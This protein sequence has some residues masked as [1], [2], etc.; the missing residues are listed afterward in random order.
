MW[1][2]YKD[3]D[4]VQTR[5]GMQL[6]TTFNGELYGLFFYKVN[7]TTQ[8]LVHIGTKLLKWNNY[9][10]TPASTTELYTGLNPRESKSFIF[11]NIF[12]FMDG[13]NY[14]EYDGETIKPVEGTIPVTTYFMTPDGDTLLDDGIDSDKIYQEV[15]VLTSLRTNRFYGD[16]TSVDYHL[17]TNNLDSASKY[18]IN[19]IV[20]GITK[21]ENIDFTVDRTTGIVTFNTA[22]IKE[23]EVYITFS[24]TIADQKERILNCTL[25]TDF[26]NSI[27][28]S[29]NPNY[30]NTIFWSERQNPRYIKET[31][32]NEAGLDFS[33]VKAIIP[34]NNVLW[35]LKE[36]NQNFSSLYYYVPT[37][38]ENY[39]DTYSRN[40]GSISLGCVSTGINFNDDIVFFSTKGLEGISSSSMYS[41][42]ILQHRS[43][44]VDSK[45]LVETGYKD[46][47]L[48]EWE[49]Y[50]LCLI[51]SHI[52]LADSRQKFQNN[53]NDIEYEWFY[54]ELP[55][56]ITYIKEY[57]GDLYLGNNS[58]QLFKLDGTSDNTRD[59]DSYWTTF[60]D[61]Y[62]YPGY[63]KTTNKR[64]NVVYFK[65]MNN[66]EVKLSTIVDGITKEKTVLNDTKGIVP[67]RIK[68]KKF[69]KIQIK[70]SSNNPFGLFSI[71]TQSFVAGYVK[72]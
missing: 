39:I 50:L 1:K 28:F 13:I 47:K 68:D 66:Q 35:V 61:D 26:N 48:A 69:R 38:D 40:N 34:G 25:V 71:S 17:N 54:W 11:D 45:L 12:F 23:S 70:L 36:M 33:S 72:R 42:Q 4:C 21:T 30:P 10:N 51:D 19:A 44:M 59:I 6:L 63:A 27:F 65:P 67:F 53:S 64:G 58:G 20:N 15:N 52:Y 55:Y 57:N 22:P 41:E 31:A 3:D 9:P 8:V 14:L 29:G 16:G 32:F 49:G 24:K 60:A 2:N 37:I 5:P 62:G 18:L 56:D 46:V 7:N 43:S